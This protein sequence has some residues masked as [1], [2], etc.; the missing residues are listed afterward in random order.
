MYVLAN[1][2]RGQVEA[3]YPGP[4]PACGPRTF[5]ESLKEKGLDATDL[6]ISL[7]KGDIYEIVRD[8]RLSR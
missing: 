3:A 4:R 2:G 1:R 5:G 6:V 8:R 7:H